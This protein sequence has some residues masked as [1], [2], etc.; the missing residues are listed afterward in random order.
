MVNPDLPRIVIS[1]WSKKILESWKIHKNEA[2]ADVV[3]K[4]VQE[5]LE[6]LQE[7]NPTF[8]EAVYTATTSYN[9]IKDLVDKEDT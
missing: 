3:D 9:K 6:A 4:L 8:N 2:I 1:N 7:E 5:R